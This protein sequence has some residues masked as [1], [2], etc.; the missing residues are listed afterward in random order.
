MGDTITVLD[1]IKLLL[2]RWKLIVFITLF[3]V[4]ISG[5]VSFYYLKP[6]YSSSTQILVN[7]KDKENQLDYSLLHR[8]VELINTYSGIIK[9]PAILEKVINKLALTTSW[10][11][12]N[13]KISVTSQENVQIFTV[14]VK[15]SDA[16]KAVQIVNTVS[17]TFQE[18][19][20]NIMSVDNVSIL[21]RAELKENPIPVS[22]KP[23]INIFMAL[24]IGLILGTGISLLI[25]FLDSTLKNEMDVVA[26]LGVPVLGSIQKMTKAEKKGDRELLIQ[27]KGGESIVPSVE[28]YR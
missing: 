26:Y 20:K 5:I 4:L 23:M 18:E 12:L 13:Q 11:G 24:V 9:S 27:N 1:I 7:Q 2:T 22:P 19:I 10:E 17:E 15:D 21:A 6:V 8:N 14:T 28:K 25:E 16:G 3:A